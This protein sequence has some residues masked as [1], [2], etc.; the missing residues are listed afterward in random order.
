MSDSPQVPADWPVEEPAPSPDGAD[1]A[2]DAEPPAEETVGTIPAPYWMAAGFEYGG[3][4][5]RLA[6]KWLDS[7]LL[8]AI[9]FVCAISLVGLLVLPFVLLGYF[10]F[11]WTRGATP[12][13][14][15]CGLRV[16]RASDGA[17][18]TAATATIRFVV[19]L[20]ET[21]AIVI[22]VGI[23]A[24]CIA[25]FD[26]RKRAWHDIAVDTVVVHA[27]LYERYDE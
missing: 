6:A 14:K 17:P 3:F 5:I 13:Q 15:I 19:E 4:W 16:A 26:R 2:L 7:L 11:F 8:A 20:V 27:Q 10:P 12:G 21:V 24:F 9:S 23:A 1:H 18:I 22:G 25:A